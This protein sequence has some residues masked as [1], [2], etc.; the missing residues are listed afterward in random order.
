MLNPDWAKLMTITNLE[1]TRTPYGRA[2]LGFAQEYG[3]VAWGLA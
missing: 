1:M 3:P 2:Y